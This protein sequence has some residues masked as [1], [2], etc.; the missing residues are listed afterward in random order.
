MHSDALFDISYN[1]NWDHRDAA[2]SILSKRTHQILQI[3]L[4]MRAAAGKI[5][6]LKVSHAATGCG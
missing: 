1:V 4:Y 5:N 3:Y 2:T 6:T